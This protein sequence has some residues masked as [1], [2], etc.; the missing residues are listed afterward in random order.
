MEIL[1]LKKTKDSDLKIGLQVCYK[2]LQGG[3]SKLGTI[4]DTYVHLRFTHYI[5]NTSFGAYLADELKL[6]KK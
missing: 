4:T 1:L 5:I 6:I 2:D 3:Y